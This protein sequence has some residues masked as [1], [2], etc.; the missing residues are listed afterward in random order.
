MRYM[1]SS[2]DEEVESP[3][4]SLIASVLTLLRFAFAVGMRWNLAIASRLASE[5]FFPRPDNVEGQPRA[6]GGQADSSDEKA[7]PGRR[8]LGEGGW[9]RLAPCE[10]AGSGARCAVATG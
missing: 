3:R 8:R 4:T 1:R 7:R 9:I 6:P 10:V 2:H 5:L